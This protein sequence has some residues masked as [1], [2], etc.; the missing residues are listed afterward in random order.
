MNPAENFLILKVARRRKYKQGGLGM[1][2]GHGRNGGQ[3]G[4]GGQC[5]H[6][7]QHRHNEYAKGFWLP[8]D[9]SRYFRKD[10]VD[11]L[12]MVDQVGIVD[13]MDMVDDFWLL[14]VTCRHFRIR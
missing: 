8:V 7:G 4:H 12:G 1:H 9:S 14:E 11:L 10:K 2:G 3:H 6:G 5:E 13:N